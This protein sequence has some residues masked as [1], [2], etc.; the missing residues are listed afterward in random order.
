[1]L[2]SWSEEVEHVV[3]EEVASWGASWPNSVQLPRKRS[4]HARCLHERPLRVRGNRSAR[5]A[6]ALGPGCLFRALNYFSKDH[7]GQIVSYEGLEIHTRDVDDAAY[8]PALK[9]AAYARF[10]SAEFYQ[11]RVVDRD[12]HRVECA[13][14]P[15]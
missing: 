5:C 14:V 6:S 11:A 3:R 15:R 2:S 13:S 7:F 4:S 9:A 10:F 1:M 8:L 12:A